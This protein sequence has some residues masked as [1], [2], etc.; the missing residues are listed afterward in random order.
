MRN[1]KSE[2]SNLKSEEGFTLIELIVVLAIMGIMAG[3]FVLNINQKRAER[4][5][6]I[7]QNQL[8]TNIRKIQ[9]YT[10]SSRAAPSGQN[11]QYYLMKFDFSK[12]TQYEVQVMYNVK[13]SPQYLLRTETISLPA[14]IRLAAASPGVITR[15]NDPLTQ[16]PAACALVAFALPFAKTLLNDGCTP[17]TPSGYPYGITSTDD[18]KKVI[19]FVNNVDCSVDPTSCSVSSDSKITITLTDTSGSI[20]KK[21]LLNG[22]T[23][24][25][26]PTLDGLVCQSTY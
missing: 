7:A 9:S 19:D 12:P 6:K 11:V 25:V 8:V 4:D 1:L 5:I 17:A 20:N 26:C 18:Y 22:I 10:L 3:V 23:G 2:I 13:S 16:T 21:V 15:Q 24:M 14:G